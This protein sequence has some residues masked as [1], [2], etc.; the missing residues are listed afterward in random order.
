MTESST[1]A[2]H[3]LLLCGKGF[4]HH[5]GEQNLA[6][7]RAGGGCGRS[8]TVILT[9]LTST[10]RVLSSWVSS[11]SVAWPVVFAPLYG[12]ICN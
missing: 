6:I 3:D 9:P 5:K 12:C 1:F 10:I 2:Y 7:R 11:L 8:S 4:G